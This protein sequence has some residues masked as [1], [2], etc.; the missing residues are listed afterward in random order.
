MRGAGLQSY[1]AWA[2]SLGYA[3]IGIPL[4]L[5]FAFHFHLGLEGLWIGLVVA[6]TFVATVQILILFRIDW[7]LEAHKAGIRVSLYESDASDQDLTI[8]DSDLI[9]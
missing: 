1:G 5:V 4:A 9:D 3:L 6:V 7:Q 2:N 8:P